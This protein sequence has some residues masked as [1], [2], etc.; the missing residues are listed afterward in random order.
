[1]SKKVLI[2][3][4]SSGFGYLAT[5]VLL[6]KGYTVVATMRA[7][8][9]RNQGPADELRALGAHV[10]DIDVADD[11][12]VESGVQKALEL[13][14]G[15]DIV[16][17]N[18]GAG[19]LGIQELFTIDDWR[20]Q[21]EVNVF[22]TQRMNRAVLPT[23]RA[24]GHGLIVYLSSIVAR[25]TFPFF[26]PYAASKAALESMAET[27][28]VEYSRLG[29]DSVVI[30]PGG[31]ATGFQASM[32]SPSDSERAASLGEYAHAPAAQIKGF[33]DAF[34]G[35]NAPSPNMVADAL[36][37]LIETE[38]GQRPFRTVVDGMGLEEPIT[39]YNDKG[40]E[41]LQATFG[42]WGMA[43]ALKLKID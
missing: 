42:N 32:R 13:A 10:V 16:I 26:G 7:S 24:Q 27:Y 17:N 43:D 25:L 35:P 18:A 14:G 12:S 23:L 15:L 28:R 39:Q 19:G 22:G 9:G 2:T 36:V 4:T 5:K 8:S 6:D 37:K 30:E 1:M 31:Y 33:E 41:V 34:K 20:W 11:A 3:G 38:P 29:I 21:F 40:A